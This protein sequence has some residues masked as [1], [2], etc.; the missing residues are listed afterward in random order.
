M[1]HTKEI[2]VCAPRHSHHP[3]H[4]DIIIIR[5][6]SNSNPPKYIW[7][8]SKGADAKYIFEAALDKLH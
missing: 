4:Y 2:C 6:N 5:W 8:F 7:L 3:L 1:L